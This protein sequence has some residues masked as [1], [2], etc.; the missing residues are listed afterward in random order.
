MVRSWRLRVRR[1]ELRARQA[2]RDR[3]LIGDLAARAMNMLSDDDLSRLR[4]ALTRE[5]G[6]DS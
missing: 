4:E 2:E 5:E 3:D 6:A 1:A